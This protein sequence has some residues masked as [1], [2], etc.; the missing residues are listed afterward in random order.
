MDRNVGTEL[1]G[2]S[3]FTLQEFMSNLIIVEF[4]T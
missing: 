4:Y 1:P 2:T 3:V